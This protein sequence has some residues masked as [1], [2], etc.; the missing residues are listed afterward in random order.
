MKKL[1]AVILLISHINSSMFF[2]I[3]EQ[4]EINSM[5]EF[6]NEKVLNQVDN[7][8]EDKDD[9]NKQDFFSFAKVSIAIYTQVEIFE[10][11]I[12]NT[13]L[14][15]KVFSEFMQPKPG[16]VCIELTSPPPDAC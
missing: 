15:P 1:F 6:V 9:Q 8:P 13:I 12:F 10:T 7:T 4:D 3:M 11:S 14:P 16:L 2:P 5:V